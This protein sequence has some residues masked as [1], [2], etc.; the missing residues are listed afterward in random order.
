MKSKNSIAFSLLMLCMFIFLSCG[1]PTVTTNFVKGSYTLSLENPSPNPL[2]I[3]IRYTG[4]ALDGK[5]LA[6]GTIRAQELNAAIYELAQLLEASGLFKS[7]EIID[8]QNTK[9][10]GKENFIME[11]S[12]AEE[13]DTHTA[14][15]AGKAFASGFFTLGLAPV[16]IKYSYSSKMEIRMLKDNSNV[17]AT[18][19]L[20][21]AD[22]SSSHMAFESN[23]SLPE[24]TITRKFITSENNRAVVDFLIKNQSKLYTQ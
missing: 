13:E 8:I 3:S 2:P 22:A 21:S 12:F 18:S 14:G 19:S 6:T 9:T 7:V 17:I 5:P 20:K 1:S 24:R 15:T 10:A 11:V 4:A 16:T 23:R